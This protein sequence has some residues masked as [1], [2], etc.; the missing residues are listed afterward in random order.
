MIKAAS[1]SSPRY[2]D[3]GDLLLE[4]CEY[5]TSEAEAYF[6]VM[7]ADHVNQQYNLYRLGDGVTLYGVHLS[8]SDYDNTSWSIRKVI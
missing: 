6:L 5:D 3:V 2:F 1:A 7:K 4:I 8:K